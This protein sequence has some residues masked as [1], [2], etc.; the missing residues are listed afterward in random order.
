MPPAHAYAPVMPCPTA[1]GYYTAVPR[2]LTAAVPP[3]AATTATPSSYL[4]RG[5]I[6]R[7]RRRR[8]HSARGAVAYRRAG[9][10]AAFVINGAATLRAVATP[11][12]CGVVLA[13]G[14]ATLYRAWR[15]D[16]HIPPATALYLRHTFAARS[17]SASACK[18]LFISS[19][20]NKRRA[21]AGADDGITAYYA[22]PAGNVVWRVSGNGVAR[23]GCWR[24]QRATVTACHMRVKAKA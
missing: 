21:A 14:A 2:L 22:V 16:A 4:S 18:P 1:A 7:R 9:W 13:A 12:C 5:A 6:N 8:L 20:R 23:G 19:G 10:R 15:R 11:A 17:T 24:R 3:P